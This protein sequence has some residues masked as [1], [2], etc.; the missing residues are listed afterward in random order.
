MQVRG[1]H[2]KLYG[3]SLCSVYLL[4]G[5]FF[6]PA[7]SSDTPYPN[8]PKKKWNISRE[9]VRPSEEILPNN[10]TAC[11]CVVFKA[12]P[13]ELI[14]LLFTYSKFASTSK[15]ETMSGFRIGPLDSGRL[16]Y[17][18]PPLRKF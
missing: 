1:R 16:L 9:A 15:Q 5:L 12:T 11:N 2:K 17:E 6:Y 8:V 18:M 14:L 4:L 10:P 3:T 7:S 13:V